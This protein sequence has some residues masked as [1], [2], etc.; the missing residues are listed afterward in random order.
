M[1]VLTHLVR[2][3]PVA[4][5]PAFS[6]ANAVS[7]VNIYAEEFL[8]EQ[9]LWI[10]GWKHRG[11]FEVTV[12]SRAVKLS[13]KELRNVLQDFSEILVTWAWSCSELCHF[14]FTYYFSMCGA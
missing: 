5:F 9:A 10:R 11:L 13:R 4:N 6:Q 7:L 14:L 1:S 12:E 3:W 8:S 2:I